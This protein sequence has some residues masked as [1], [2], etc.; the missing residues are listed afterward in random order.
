MHKYRIHLPVEEKT[1]LISAVCLGQSP[2]CRALVCGCVCVCQWESQTGRQTESEHGRE[3]RSRET[4][5][6]RNEVLS[7]T[8]NRKCGILKIRHLDNPPG[9]L[10]RVQTSGLQNICSLLTPWGGDSVIGCGENGVFGSDP[11]GL[12]LWFSGRRDWKCNSGS[13]NWTKGVQ[14]FTKNKKQSKTKQTV[15]WDDTAEKAEI[16][17]SVQ[18]LH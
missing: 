10:H 16:D 3:G 9:V 8:W 5:C 4:K 1:C 17:Y 6:S 15:Y 7:R 14:W 2:P 13:N 12:Q 11:S 18:V